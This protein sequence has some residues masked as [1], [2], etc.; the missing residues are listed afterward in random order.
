MYKR[1]R[2]NN[3]LSCVSISIVSKNTFNYINK[4]LI[5]KGVSKSQIKIPR[6][7]NNKKEILKILKDNS[8]K[9]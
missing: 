9:V 7:I 5:S 3:R 4:Y 2:K 8:I 1:F 6:V